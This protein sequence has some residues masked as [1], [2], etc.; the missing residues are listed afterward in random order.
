MTPFTTPVKKLAQKHVLICAG[1]FLC[2]E[3]TLDIPSMGFIAVME[4]LVGVTRASQI[5]ANA[6]YFLLILLSF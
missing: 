3:F 6:P 5:S 1:I 2:N 4:L